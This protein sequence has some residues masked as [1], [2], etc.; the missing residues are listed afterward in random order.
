KDIIK[1]FGNRQALL[2]GFLLLGASAGIQAQAPDSWAGVWSAEQTIIT[3]RVV[4]AGNQFSVEP[5]E[6]GGLVWTT[7]NGVIHGDMGSIEVEYQGVT[8][9]LMVQLIDDQTAIAH[10]VSCQP[11]YHV[12]C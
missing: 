12:L 10:A 2:A 5:I 1:V 11:D 3:L 8:G 9:K 4:R 6:S 7:R